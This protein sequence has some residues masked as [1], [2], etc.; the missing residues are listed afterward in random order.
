MVDLLLVRRLSPWMSNVGK[1]LVRSPKVYIR[2]SGLVHALLNIGT[3]DGLFGHPVAGSSWE[4][5][6]IENLLTHLPFG[7]DAGFY[8]TSGGAEIDLVLSLPPH[9]LWAIEIKRSMAPK[10]ERGCHLACEDLQPSARFVVYPGTER[11]SL[12]PN[13]TAISLPD[14]VGELIR[15]CR[16]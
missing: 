3:L 10:P 5:L 1:R 8:R 9:D 6:V 16:I 13:L 15:L 11:F 4:G 12:G 2:D 7:A 14:L